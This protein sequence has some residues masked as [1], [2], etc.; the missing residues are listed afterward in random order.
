MT[1]SQATI[2][3]VG[4][5][6]MGTGIAQVASSAGRTV[7]VTDS[8]EGALEKSRSSLS[9]TFSKL[10][11]KGKITE[12]ESKN[13][14]DRI[15]HSRSVDAFTSCDIVVEA[16]VEDFKIKK[17]ILSL[18]ESKVSPGCILASNTSSLS[19]AALGGTCKNPE[20][21]IGIHFFNPAPLMSLVEIVPSL[22]TSDE[23]VEKAKRLVAGCGKKGVIAKDT[24]GFIVNRIA[25][26]YYGE[27]IRI[28]EEGI[29]SKQ[30]I[31]WALK[32]I[33]GF[34]MGPFELMD[35][36]GNDVNFAVTTSV[37]EAFFHDPKYKPSLTQKRLVEAGWL[38]KKTGKGHYDYKNEDR[39]D[40][41]INKEKAQAIVDR[42]L[43]M[44]INEAV[45][46]LFLN[47]ASK[48]DI[49][50]AMTLGTNYPKGLLKWCD[51]IGSKEILRRM[52]ALSDR[53]REDRYRA[54][55]LLR[56]MNGRSFY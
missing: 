37:Y 41:K 2:G 30:E 35:L 27:S 48:E 53:Y 49:D 33:G 20:R 23:V 34:K 45:D 43:A 32:E 51:E 1:N 44:L 54:S 52:D 28:F 12:L 42:V 6:T 11:A 55:P 22:M 19:I 5:G 26:P 38:G 50:L 24:P 13:I 21:I 18:L 7:I 31:D 39:S 56:D 36:I 10:V 8:N 17:E 40:V 15:S 29:A 25:R 16:V 3:I 46:A 47:I 4:A 14:L 9:D